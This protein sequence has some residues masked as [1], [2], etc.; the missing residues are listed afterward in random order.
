[1]GRIRCRTRAVPI[2]ALNDPILTKHPEPPDERREWLL[3]PARQA[4]I[5]FGVLLFLL[6]LFTIML[7]AAIPVCAIL[8]LKDIITTPGAASVLG[9]ITS[10][11]TTLLITLVRQAHAVNGSTSEPDPPSHP[12]PLAKGC[13]HATCPL[14]IAP[15]APTVSPNE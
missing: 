8:R 12:L 11:W 3:T 4:E 10:A 9:S 5:L 7:V 2:D 14:R 15:A 1:M 6:L 13:L